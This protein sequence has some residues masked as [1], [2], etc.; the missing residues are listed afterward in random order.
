MSGITGRRRFCAF[1]LPALLLFT[2]CSSGS[3]LC[4]SIDQLETDVRAL[5]EVNVVDDGIDALTTQVDAV[6]ASFDAVKQEATETFSADIAAVETAAQGVGTIVEQ[7]QGGTTL[8]DVLSQATTAIS[9]LVTSVEALIQTAREQE[10]G[11]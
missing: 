8:T 5:G 10:C 7:V 11:S 3:A 4:Q 9:A 1:A 6:S 2:A